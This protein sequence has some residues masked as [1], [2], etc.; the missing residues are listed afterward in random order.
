[1]QSSTSIFLDLNKNTV[2]DWS[3]NC[4]VICQESF[5]LDSNFLIG[6]Y[7]P[8]ETPKVVEI[9]ESHFFKRKYNR[10]R[11]T[12]AQWVFG[13]IERGSRQC[14]LIPVADRST[15][16]LLPIIEE[17]VRPGTI[18]ISYKWSSFRC[19]ADSRNYVHRVVNHSLNFVSPDDSTIHT[20]NIENLWHHIKRRLKVQYGTQRDMLDG[21]L[22]EF[23]WKMTVTD[24]KKGLT[25]LLLI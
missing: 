25:T 19:L 7:N 11:D 20:Q 18:I 22:F 12:D 4:R 10:G 23:M 6:G 3:L 9:D 8:D 21:Y 15:A 2:S 14:V 1:M 13:M 24:K 17:H 5:Y 16:T